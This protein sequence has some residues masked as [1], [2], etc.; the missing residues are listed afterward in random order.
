MK[1]M[2]APRKDERMRDVWIRENNFGPMRRKEGFELLGGPGRPGGARVP[3]LP[4]ILVRQL[5]STGG[6]FLNQ[7]VAASPN[8]NAHKKGFAPN[9]KIQSMVDID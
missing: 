3:L 2:T 8:I 6:L 1:F 9:Y 5:S 4:L 7:T